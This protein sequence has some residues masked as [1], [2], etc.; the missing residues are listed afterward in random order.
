[1]RGQ[2]S[3]DNI[4]KA[5]L[6]IF[7]GSFVE[8]SGKIIRI[9]TTCEGE[10]IEIKIQLTAAKDILGGGQ[11]VVSSTEAKE[12]T[13]QDRELTEAEIAEIKDLITELGL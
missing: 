3:K 13:P 7:S 4:T 12:Y 6:Q 9:P 5:I 8:P 1:M 2:L 11:T 10:N